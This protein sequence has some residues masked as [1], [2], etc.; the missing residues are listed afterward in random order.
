MPLITILVITAAKD[1]FEDWRRHKSDNE[2]N[3]RKIKVY[4]PEERCFKDVQWFQLRVGDI[5]HVIFH[6]PIIC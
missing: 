1:F 5:V 6:N 2:E 4:Y 3:K